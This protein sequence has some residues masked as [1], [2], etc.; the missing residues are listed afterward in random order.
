M[1]T[2]RLGSFANL[3]LGGLFLVAAVFYGATLWPLTPRVLDIRDFDKLV[4]TNNEGVIRAGFVSV[5]NK[6]AE[7]ELNVERLVAELVLLGLAIPLVHF[8]VTWRSYWSVEKVRRRDICFVLS[9]LLI[10]FLFALTVVSF[11][12]YN[13]HAVSELKSAQLDNALF[14]SLVGRANQMFAR[15]FLVAQSSVFLFAGFAIFAF[16]MHRYIRAQERAVSS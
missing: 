13:S 3:V 12:A 11:A 15:G 14:T 1:K 10:F 7:F 4:Q 2:I 16:Y 9:L 5:L 8:V 6:G